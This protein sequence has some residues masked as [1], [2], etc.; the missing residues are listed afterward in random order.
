MVNQSG[1]QTN[2]QNSTGMHTTSQSNT[3]SATNNG[4][5]N[6]TYNWGTYVPQLLPPASAGGMP[7]MKFNFLSSQAPASSGGY[8]PPFTAD[9]YAA[10]LMAG[11]PRAQPNFNLE[12]ILNNMRT[13]PT[14]N[15]TPNNSTSAPPTNPPPVYTTPP[16]QPPNPDQGPG[17]D[18]HGGVPPQGNFFN[19]N[20]LINNVNYADLFRGLVSN[21]TAPLW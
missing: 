7:Q 14:F 9:P 10:M 12:A 17:P 3:P 15:V 8:L 5:P 13:R 6:T 2:I 1:I 19:L 4:N 20:D 11:M 18:P 21:Q 16:P